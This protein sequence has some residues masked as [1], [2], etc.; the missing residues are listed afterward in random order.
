[1]AAGSTCK[2]FFHRP[3]RELCRSA[4]QGIRDPGSR[5][6]FWSDPPQI[7][8]AC[9]HPCPATRRKSRWVPFAAS[10]AGAI[11]L[12]VRDALRT[13]SAP[14]GCVAHH[15]LQSARELSRFETLRDESPAAAADG[16]TQRGPTELFLKCV[17]GLREQWVHPT[18]ESGIAR[19]EFFQSAH[20]R[21][22]EI[23][24]IPLS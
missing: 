22:A 24:R 16:P 21:A 15:E 23:P 1:M 17:V 14:Q 5:S 18:G 13:Q 6:V 2:L 11:L 8:R 7:P 10:H 4:L 3:K 9:T 19:R 12:R 20:A